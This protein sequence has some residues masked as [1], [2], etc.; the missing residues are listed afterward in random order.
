MKGGA[1]ASSFERRGSERLDTSIFALGEQLEITQNTSNIFAIMGL[2]FDY[3]KQG[4]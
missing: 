3:G 2:T 4:S 1:R